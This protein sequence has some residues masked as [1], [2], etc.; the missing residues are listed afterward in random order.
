MVKR[1]TSANLFAFLPALRVQSTRL[2]RR[3]GYCPLCDCYRQTRYTGKE[4]LTPVWNRWGSRQRSRHS[5]D[6]LRVGRTRVWA[7]DSLF[8]SP[9]HTGSAAHPA[10]PGVRRPGR[11]V[12]HSSPIYH[13]SYELV[14]LYLH[15]C[16]AGYGETFTVRDIDRRSFCPH[17]RSFVY[18]ELTLGIKE[19]QGSFYFSIRLRLSV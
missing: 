17:W 3:L 11:S 12:A 5:D 19:R 10:F 14:K 16:M 6:P 18:L 8:D 13:R 1:F 4:V 9:V 15:S 7:R 2:G